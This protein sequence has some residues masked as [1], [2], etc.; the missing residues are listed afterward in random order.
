TSRLRPSVVVSA[1]LGEFFRGFFDGSWAPKSTRIWRSHSF[2]QHGPSENKDG[3]TTG[4]GGDGASSGT[5]DRALDDLQA[6]LSGLPASSRPRLAPDQQEE[7]VEDPRADSSSDPPASS[8][9]AEDL[10]GGGERSGLYGSA[11]GRSRA[12]SSFSEVEDGELAS[13]LNRRIG[14]IAAGTGQYDS[15]MTEEEMRQPLTGAELRELIYTKYGKT[16]D[17]SFVRRDIPG[18]TFVCLNIMWSHLE[19]RSFKLTEQQYME[20][21]DGV[22][23]LLGALGQTNV[24]R[25]FLR[26][27]ARSQKGLPARPVVGTAVSIRFDLEQGVI[28]EWFGKGY[29]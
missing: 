4:S 2:E 10:R 29:Q 22:A 1:G 6:R 27:K 28:E 16:Y 8:A 15:E 17:V 24:V 5:S 9:S 13:A 25:A 19:Q 21:L 18:K 14:Q 23:Y 26:E 7:D 12:V 3:G 11:G 20:K